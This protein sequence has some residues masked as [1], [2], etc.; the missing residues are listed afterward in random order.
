MAPKHLSVIGGGLSVRNIDLNTVP[1][2][3]IGV[4]DSAIH[5]PRV[6]MVVSMDRLWTEYRWDKLLAMDKPTWLRRNAI[7]NTWAK[8]GETW[9]NLT[10]FDNKLEPESFSRDPVVLHGHNSG[11]CA[12]NLA[13]QLKPDHLWIFGFDMTKGSTGDPYWYEPYPWKP[14]GATKPGHYRVWARQ[15]ERMVRWLQAE[16]IAVSIVTD[17]K[18]AKGVPFV[19][20]QDYRRS[21]P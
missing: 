19:S 6:D 16:G 10:V 11:A 21:K 1:G 2:Q 3:V 8:G 17:T 5:A 14:E 7:K 15:A 13:F 4:N 18:W 12:L 20:T 9:K